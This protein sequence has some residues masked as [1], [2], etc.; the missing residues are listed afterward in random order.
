ML[1][2]NNQSSNDEEDYF[3]AFSDA[4]GFRPPKKRKI[5][6]WSTETV[7]KTEPVEVN[8]KPLQ[9]LFD[10]GTSAT[11][12]LKPF[13][14]KSHKRPTAHSKTTWHMMGGTFQTTEKRY[15]KFK[16]PE[17]SLSKSIKWNCHVDSNSDPRMTNYDLII[18][19]D[20]MTELQLR[21][22]F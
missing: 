6:R 8:D 14:K 12:I 20:L 22:D 9:V 16:L 21:M 11:I 1:K 7:A 15:V 5:S 2:Q 18:G 13:V 3:P 10:T 4:I 17:F 19:T